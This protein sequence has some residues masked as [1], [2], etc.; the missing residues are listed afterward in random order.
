MK[1]TATLE[2]EHE[3]NQKRLQDLMLMMS[4][5]D[6][7]ETGICTGTGSF[8]TTDSEPF[9]SSAERGRKENMLH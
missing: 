5:S 3:A 1:L 4:H 6:E 7:Q 9:H 2:Q 8:S